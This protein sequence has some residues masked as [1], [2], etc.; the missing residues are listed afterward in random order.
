[1]HH[2][3]SASVLQHAVLSDAPQHCAAMTRCKQSCW[4]IAAPRTSGVAPPRL[5]EGHVGFPQKFIH[6]AHCN[7]N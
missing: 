6:S 2:M 5:A 7:T 4:P 1:M 3:P